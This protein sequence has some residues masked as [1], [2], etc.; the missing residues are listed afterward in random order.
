MVRGHPHRDGDVEGFSLALQAGDVVAERQVGHGHVAGLAAAEHEFE[1]HAVFGGPAHIA[2]RADQ[3][4]VL[5]CQVQGPQQRMDQRGPLHT[6]A[7]SRLRR[8]HH[9]AQRRGLQ[10]QHAR[11]EDGGHLRRRRDVIGVPTAR[12]GNAVEERAVPVVAQTVGGDA[13]GRRRGLIG[14]L[15]AHHLVAVGLSI[16]EQDEV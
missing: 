8:Q 5:G 1:Q 6:R 15:Q 13:D 2:Q 10:R 7:G 3:D 14:M 12:P 11:A 4:A 16:G 9:L